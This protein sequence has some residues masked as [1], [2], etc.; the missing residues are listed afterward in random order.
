MPVRTQIAPQPARVGKATVIVTG[1]ADAL[2]E[3]LAGVHVQIEGDM[4]HPGMAPVF[5]DAKEIAPGIY[6]A[7]LDFNMPGDWI[8]LTHIR[9]A[10]GH[11]IE[12]QTDVRGVTAQ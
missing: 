6:R 3:P 7:Q 11:T 9:L 5:S 2:G 10:N 12:R 1:I 4:A 8:V